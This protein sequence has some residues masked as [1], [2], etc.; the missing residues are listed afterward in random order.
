MVDQPA[1]RQRI[2]AVRRLDVPVA[3]AKVEEI[4]VD[5]MVHEPGAPNQWKPLSPKYPSPMYSLAIEPKAR[6][7]ETKI[8]GALHKLA[9]EDPTF[10]F[11]HDALRAPGR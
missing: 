3:L 2:L 9:E 7:D 1:T 4:H 6:G 11:T 10:T 8:S 5:N